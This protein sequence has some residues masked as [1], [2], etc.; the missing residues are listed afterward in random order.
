MVNLNNG[1]YWNAL[2]SGLVRFSVICLP[3]LYLKQILPLAENRKT[4]I[5]NIPKI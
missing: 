3:A 2:D 4:T 1:K 5:S